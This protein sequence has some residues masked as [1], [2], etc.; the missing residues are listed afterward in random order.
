[1]IFFVNFVKFVDMFPYQIPKSIEDTK[2]YLYTA[3][4]SLFLKRGNPRTYFYTRPCLAVRKIVYMSDCVCSG[5]G[6]IV[7]GKGSLL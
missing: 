5:Y 6:S 4:V 2:L 7:K 1:M 3:D